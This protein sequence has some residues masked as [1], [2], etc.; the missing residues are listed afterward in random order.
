MLQALPEGLLFLLS[1][2]LI[3]A[4]MV[5]AVLL[6][7]FFGMVPGLGGT[8]A[9]ALF[10]PLMIGVDPLIGMVFLISMHA[11]V[12]TAGS[13]PSIL[14]GIP[15]TGADAATVMDGLPLTRKGQAGR[16]LGASLLA[17]GIG[18]VVGALFLMLMMPLLEPLIL[19]ITPAEYFLL[20]MLGI[21]FISA[22]SGK[23]LRKGIAVGCLGLCLSFVGLAPQTG[24]P[25]YTLG[26]VF[27]WGGLD[28]LSLVLAIFA[29][30]ELYSMI[31]T[32]RQTPH[33]NPAYTT[34]DVLGG[35][36]EVLKHKWLT[37]RTSIM[38]AVIGFIPGLGGD[39][40]SWF[41]YGHA[42]Q[43]SKHPEQFGKGAIEGV[44][45]PETAN[46][47]KEGGALIPTL[48]F[49]IPGSSGMAVLLLA[50]VV[51]DIQPGPGLLLDQPEL[52][53]TLIVALVVANLLAVVILLVAGRHLAACSSLPAG[54]IFPVGVVMVVCGS[55]VSSLS[56]VYLCI[57]LA[58]SL[59]G[60]WLKK[61]N[62]PRAPFVIGLVLGSRAELSLIQAMTIWGYD[63]FLRPVSLVLLAAMAGS[64]VIYFR[65][66][67]RLPQPG[68]GL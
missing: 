8:L 62:W 28:Y 25:R 4:L 2:P 53:A 42:V 50:L 68:K 63:F 3:P 57:M 16:A 56:W 54:I 15:G 22:V 58:V 66:R 1:D 40:A 19:M 5:M 23:S 18:G 21:S 26:Q 67:R 7:I 55:Y 35:M 65:L 29:L 36:R 14:F 41:C 48:L 30:P 13:I 17:S 37:L 32:R 24:E 11:V 47:S 10:I 45:A 27:L 44:I 64:L 51:L 43:S 34:S 6:G 31:V 20:T 59:P 60:Y 9:I 39:V 52:I 61:H 49:G 46:N 33:L 38:G 12:H